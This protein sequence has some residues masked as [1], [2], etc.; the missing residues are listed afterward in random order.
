[1]AG[2][3]HS[4]SSAKL[5]V[6]PG[7][8]NAKDEVFPPLSA[9]SNTAEEA[10]IATLGAEV[11]KS[12][13][14]DASTSE[15]DSEDEDSTS[16]S[17]SGSVRKAR[18]EKKVDQTM[19]PLTNDE[20]H[21]L[22]MQLRR[23]ALMMNASNGRQYPEGYEP[24]ERFMVPKNH[25]V[26][27][28]T[29]DQVERFIMAMELEHQKWTRGPAAD[30][31]QPE[32]ISKLGD[33]FKEATAARTWFQLYA[34]ERVQNGDNLTWSHLAT[35][36]RNHFG[37]HD[38]PA[39]SFETFWDF[40]QGSLSVVEY[41]TEKKQ[42][43][44]LC[45]KDLLP[46]VYLWGYTRGLKPEIQTYVKLQNVNKV[47]EAQEFA[48]KFEESHNIVKSTTT[49]SNKTK[50]D[51]LVDK[52]RKFD[53]KNGKGLSRSFSNAQQDARKQ[54]RKLKENKCYGCGLEGHMRDKCT[55]S[56]EAKRAFKDELVRLQ[57][58]AQPK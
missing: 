54:I 42:L 14:M 5:V 17:S 48:I 45:E 10:K 19:L 55:S 31:H 30:E 34:R 33:Y 36:M 47:S 38:R 7:D 12:S 23:P 52:K 32:F 25:P 53:E 24:K 43:A 2:K 6:P 50:T 37:A 21:L 29:P 46:Q 13:E 27:D 15:S 20:I 58:I 56:E 4:R 28:G 49:R 39:I 22:R 11:E 1:M 3:K 44:L 51:L 18:N 41:T 8:Q 40:K 26:F 16:G 9:V 35:T 57:Q